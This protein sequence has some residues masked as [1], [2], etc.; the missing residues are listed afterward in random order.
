M[1]AAAM[2]FP[3]DTFDAAIDKGE[4]QSVYC[5]YMQYKPLLAVLTMIC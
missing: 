3:A 1:N 5:S 2:T 4:P